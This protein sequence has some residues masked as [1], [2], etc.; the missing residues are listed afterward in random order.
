MKSCPHGEI[1]RGKT[2]DADVMAIYFPS[3]HPDAR[4]A[5]WYGEGFS[6]WELLKTTKPLFDGHRQPKVPSWGY[7]DES[8]PVWMERQIE[9]A[10]NHGVD[11]F[12]FDWYWY[13]GEKFLE[14]ALESG[15]LG[16][17]NKNKM[18]FSLM[19]ANHDWGSWPALT[20][21][22]GMGSKENQ[23]GGPFLRI[24]HSTEDLSRVVEYC[25]ENYFHHSNYW[26]VDGRDVSSTRETEWERI[27]GSVGESC[28]QKQKR[29][30]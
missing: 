6:E 13:Q 7:F 11:G 14:K 18:K 15:F 16:S 27:S 19:W 8:D 21:V 23:S 12:I 17:A 22:P 4:Y 26:R 24:K 2:V 5:E 3:W 20:G 10:A 9:L 29:R 30:I 1:K 25:A 28:F